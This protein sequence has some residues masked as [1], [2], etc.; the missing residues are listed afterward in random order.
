MNDTLIPNGQV[1]IFNFPAGAG[2][3]MLQNCVGLSRHCVLTKLEYAE[4]QI[5]YQNPIDDQFYY[6]KLQWIL[7]TLPAHMPKPGETSWLGWEF[8]TQD[9]Y[10]IDHTGFKMGLPVLDAICKLAEKKLWSTITTHNYNGSVYYDRYWP[11]RQYIDLI[12]NT[13]FAR[14]T[15]PLKNTELLY[16]EKWNTHGRSSADQ[17]F[18]FD[19]DS[20]IYDTTAFVKQVD[21]LY[22]YLGFDDFQTDLIAKYHHQYIKLHD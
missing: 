20:C 14:K 11:T 5:N 9:L 6:Q 2:G 7:K 15:L 13:Q 1:I 16:D 22:E 8:L 4:W 17:C 10:G 21:N 18:E 19:I 12:N 3:K